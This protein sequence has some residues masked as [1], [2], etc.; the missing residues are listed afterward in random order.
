MFVRRATARSRGEAGGS[1]DQ[2]FRRLS[3]GPRI[4]VWVLALG[5]LVGAVVVG[6]V[7]ARL[8]GDR[9]T[10]VGI[11]ALAGVALTTLRHW[12]GVV[13][14]VAVTV[15]GCFGVL[16]GELLVHNYVLTGNP[17]SARG[18]PTLASIV[19]FV[20]AAWKLQRADPGRP[21]LGM[22]LTVA[23][24]W[25]TVV[26]TMLASRSAEVA[27]VALAGVVYLCVHGR[28]QG[29]RW[30]GL[31]LRLVQAQGTLQQQVSNLSDRIDSAYDR[32]T[33]ANIAASTAVGET[34]PPA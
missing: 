21:W 30:S 13:G 28:R 11:A 25:L 8:G 19:C 33:A 17:I 15:V 29:W 9:W 6:D 34:P 10:A 5:V 32:L 12:L 14:S 24:G 27:C 3:A 20:V 31:W 22:V 16:M 23:L 7:V 26:G 2:E 4:P 18:V 1:A